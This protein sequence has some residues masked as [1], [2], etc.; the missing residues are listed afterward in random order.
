M[1]RLSVKTKGVTI[2]SLVHTS[3][4]PD[5]QNIPKQKNLFVFEGARISGLASLVAIL[6]RAELFCRGDHVTRRNFN[7]ANTI[8]FA[9]FCVF[10]DAN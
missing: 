5:S 2:H 3:M 7:L 8:I 10:T 6:D 9:N 4:P 1:D